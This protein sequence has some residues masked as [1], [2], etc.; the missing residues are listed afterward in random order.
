M[1]YLTAFVW[2]GGAYKTIIAGVDPAIH[3]PRKMP[4]CEGDGTAGDAVV[5]LS[6]RGAAVDLHHRN[7]VCGPVSAGGVACALPAQHC[8]PADCSGFPRLPALRGAR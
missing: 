3:H 2:L 6:F 4:S 1:C 5:G 8:E 7:G